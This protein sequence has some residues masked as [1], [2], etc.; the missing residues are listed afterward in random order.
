ME[1]GRSLGAARVRAAR[2]PANEPDYAPQ[3]LP[4]AASACFR[5]TCASSGFRG[6]SAGTATV[7]ACLPAGTPR[8]GTAVPGVGFTRG[9][10]KSRSTAWAAGSKVTTPVPSSRSPMARPATSRQRH[11]SK[12][13]AGRLWSKDQA[14]SRLNRRHSV[15]QRMRPKLVGVA[16][17]YRVSRLDSPHSMRILPLRRKFPVSS[18]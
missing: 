18:A 9:I 16:R 15:G 17:W 1:E 6:A 8:D 3:V 11:H 7:P 12:S 4:S 13:G 2:P 10:G 5:E 14:P